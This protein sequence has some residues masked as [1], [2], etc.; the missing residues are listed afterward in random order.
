M[1]F[2]NYTAQ[3][4]MKLHNYTAQKSHETS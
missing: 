4:V 1:T 3:K 2:H